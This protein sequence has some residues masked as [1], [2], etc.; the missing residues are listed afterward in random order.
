M[1]SSEKVNFLDP[2]LPRT[3]LKHFN[4]RRGRML[5]RSSSRCF[6]SHSNWSVQSCIDYAQ[7]TLS[8][9]IEKPKDKIYHFSSLHHG[10]SKKL[11][12]L[13]WLNFLEH[14]KTQKRSLIVYLKSIMISSRREDLQ[15]TDW[16]Q[17][18]RK[19]W[20]RNEVKIYLKNFSV[21]MIS[22]W[23]CDND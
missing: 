17:R 2:N 4:S 5:R 18:E 10:Y 14:T 13:L 16:P 22:V 15:G 11:T 7:L 23:L 20:K 6:W 12:G 8:R 21:R 3:I 19:I 9:C 1:T